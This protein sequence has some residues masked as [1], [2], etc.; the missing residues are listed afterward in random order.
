MSLKIANRSA[1][2]KFAAGLSL[3]LA[4]A[5]CGGK[6][7]K[8]KL[9][10]ERISVLTF[11]QQLEADPTI[12]SVRVALPAPYR[13]TNW[14]Q[15]GGVPPHVMHHLALGDS[16]KQVWKTSIGAGSRK[17][18]RLVSG[19]VIADGVLYVVDTNAEVSAIDAANGRRI[20]SHRLKK[21]GQ[22][23]RLA[24][25]GGVTYSGGRVFVT[26]GYGFVAA[27]D[28]GS[29]RE[30]WRYDK[31]I[32]IRGGATVAQGRVFV[33]THDN[34]LIAL[35]AET[36][37]VIW[38]QVAIAENAGVLGAASPAVQLD[39][40]IGAFSSGELMAMR[41]DNGRILWQDALTRTARMTALAT[42]S[43]IDGQPIIDRGRVYA[44]SHAGRLV[45]IDIRSGE[46][47]W[48]SNIGGINTPWIAGDFMFV[49]TTEAE[50]AA[51]SLRDGRVRWITQLQKFRNANDR[52]GLIYWSGPVLAGDRLLVASSEGYLLSL[53]PYDGDILSGEKIPGGTVIPPVVA[54][55]TLYVLTDGG[56]LIAYR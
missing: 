33:M 44:I 22:K 34:Q 41:A 1:A 39:T 46:R 14:A 35:V 36:G 18:E 23:R 43:D 13:N 12:A 28:A 47:V 52:K 50:I 32:P 10:G 42:L 17:Y 40:V 20:W 15:P 16:L 3:S 25:G 48:E 24:Y 7:A 27:L 31:N 5:A 51:V 45:S 9:P 37:E 6:T 4:V 30:L 26:T 54:N 49:V 2:W 21:E 38:E 8:P 56:D 11:E 55:E 29:G 53:S 19:P